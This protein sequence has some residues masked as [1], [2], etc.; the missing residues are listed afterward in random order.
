MGLFRKGGHRVSEVHPV[1]LSE[2]PLAG[3]CQCGQ[4]RYVAN[5]EPLTYY[6]CHCT[7]CRRQSGSAFGSSLHFPPG[8]VALGGETGHLEWR[9]GSGRLSDQTFCPF[10]GTRVLHAIR[11]SDFVVVKPGTLDDPSFL[12]PAGHI[13][14]AQRLPWVELPDDGSLV[15]EE[16]PDMM[17]LRAHFGAMLA[18]G[19]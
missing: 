15:Y 1:R 18:R 14:A 8:T 11:D 17:A 5:V 4:L 19:R 9:G 16:A 10:C 13:F 6:L 7:M 3:G 2:L 12:H